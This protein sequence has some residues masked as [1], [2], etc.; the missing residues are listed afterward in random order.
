MEPV[1]WDVIGAIVI[2]FLA[3]CI[4]AGVWNEMQKWST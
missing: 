1:N 4:A 2:V 3:V